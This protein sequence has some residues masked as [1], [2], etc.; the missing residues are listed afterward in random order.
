MS[1]QS[2]TPWQTWTEIATAAVILGIVPDY[3]KTSMLR[4]SANL[5]KRVAD[6][7]VQKRKAGSAQNAKAEFRAKDELH[8]TPDEDEPAVI[9]TVPSL[10]DV[11]A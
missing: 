1:T 9:I 4:L 6:G 11:L 5:H 3:S 7:S 10:D 8:T 2:W